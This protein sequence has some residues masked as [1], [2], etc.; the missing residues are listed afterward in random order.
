MRAGLL[1]TG[2]LGTGTVLVFALAGLVATMFPNGSLVASSW[3]GGFAE[4]GWGKGGVRAPMPMPI[5]MPASG[6]GVDFSGKMIT[7]DGA[8]EAPEQVPMPGGTD[9]DFVS[10]P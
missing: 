5:P 9:R 1:V 4:G 8:P 6:P 3:N 7:I 2:V 10:Q